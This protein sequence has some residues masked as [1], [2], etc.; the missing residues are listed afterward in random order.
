MSM[1]KPRAGRATSP[2]SPVI[3]KLK[4][5]L[6]LLLLIFLG[7]L[8]SG[9]YVIVINSQNWLLTPKTILFIEP[10]TYLDH[11]RMVLVN[12]LPDRDQSQLYL[13]RLPVLVTD[14]IAQN[15][16][17]RF[18]TQQLGVFVD[19]VIVVSNSIP[20]QPNRLAWWLILESLDRIKDFNQ[21]FRY[22]LISGYIALINSTQ[23]TNLADNTQLEIWQKLQKLVQPLSVTS[24]QCPIMVSNATNLPGIANNFAE[25]INAQGGVVVRVVNHEEKSPSSVVLIDQNSFEC[26][27]VAELINR[28]LHD[29]VEV[30]KTEGLFGESRSKIEIRLGAEFNQFPDFQ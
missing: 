30:Q 25:F 19:Q 11:E 3:R 28:Y 5:T 26:L 18:V 29:G 1:L 17:Q 12:F 23:A 15:P 10:T 27:G 21:E 8:A 22:S 9:F 16:D 7:L 6:I 13:L 24:Y 2:P 14:A 20:D 4:I